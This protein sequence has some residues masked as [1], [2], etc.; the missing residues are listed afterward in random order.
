MVLKKHALKLLVIIISIFFIGY[1]LELF[2]H[3]SSVVSD[4][5]KVSTELLPLVLSFSIF[6]ITWMAYNKSRDNHS[7]FMGA[8][9]FIIGLLNLYHMLSY[10]FIPDFITQNSPE[11]SAVFWS[12]TVAVSALLFLASAYI[13]KDTFPRLINKTAL[14][15]SIVVISF[16]SLAVELF[17]HDYLPAMYRPDGEPS[18][19][20]LFLLIISAAIILYGSM[21]YSKRFRETQQNNIFCI[22]YSFI[23]LVSSNLV[24][25]VHDYAGSLLKAASFYFVY[26]ALYKSSVEEPYEKETEAETKLRRAAEERYKNL[27]DGASDAIITTDLEG[28]VVSWNRSA[29]NIFGWTAQEAMGKKL[30]RLTVPPEKQVENELFIH[31]ILLGRAVSGIGTT[32]QKRDGT[33]MDVSLTVSPVYNADHKIIGISCIVRDVTDRNR[34]LEMRMENMRLGLEIKAKAEFLTAMS[35]DL[36]TPLNGI[37]GFSEL[38]KQK[39][40]GELNKKQEQYVENVLASARRMLDIINDIL[41]LGRA[42]TG[43]IDLNIEK[44]SVP[45][46]IDDI[47]NLIKE[48]ITKHNV[49]LKKELDPE[50]EFIEADRQRFG[51]MLFNLVGNAVKFSKP[52]GGTVTI[53]TKKEG[54]MGRVAVSDNG[55]GIREEDMMKLFR[56]FEQLDL[57]IASKYGSTGLGLAVTKKLVELHGGKITAESRHGEGS[58]FTF[59]IPIEGKEKN[60]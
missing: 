13:Y 40:H 38:L 25:V 23:I 10:T 55:I 39:M 4:Y 50:L 46:A 36:G 45:E 58:T 20:L 56:T 16:A 28:R 17:Y 52:E 34:A 21:L 59:F 37:I 31:N 6:V 33:R 48:K 9:F 3:F 49:V 1:S 19:S 30:S 27:V 8:A 35:H 22:I 12:E 18:L 2:T 53:S 15:V 26:I 42:E 7:L 47:E 11:K 54:G 41:D 32:Y 51:Q 24:Y 29:E 43:K 57:G 60:R 5:F 44:I 14:F